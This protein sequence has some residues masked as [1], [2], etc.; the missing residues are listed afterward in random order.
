MTRPRGRTWRSLVLWAEEAWDTTQCPGTIKYRSDATAPMRV[1]FS[2]LKRDDAL[3]IK[4]IL[5]AHDS[6]GYVY[7]FAFGYSWEQIPEYLQGRVK[8]DIRGMVREMRR[9]TLL[10]CP[11]CGADLVLSGSRRCGETYCIRQDCTYRDTWGG[12]SSSVA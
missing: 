12:K 10:P 1:D 3:D 11:E 4:M 5:N 2:D 7:H 9:A 6:T 8:V